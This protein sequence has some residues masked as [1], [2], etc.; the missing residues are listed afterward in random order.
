MTKSLFKALRWQTPYGV[1]GLN[2]NFTS[3]YARKLC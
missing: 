1:G 2:N 3:L